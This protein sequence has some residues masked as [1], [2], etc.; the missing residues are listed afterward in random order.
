M[1]QASSE[2][3]AAAGNGA[4][5]GRGVA[6]GHG[7]ARYGAAARHGA[8]TGHGVVAGRGVGIAWS[9][10]C[11]LFGPTSDGRPLP[12]THSVSRDRGL[13]RTRGWA[14]A[15]ERGLSAETGM[16]RGGLRRLRRVHSGRGEAGL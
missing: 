10:V 4:G 2:F 11:A 7:F 14:A 5:M 16:D 8:A 1:S 15:E 6:T 3:A 9:G 12:G 13:Q